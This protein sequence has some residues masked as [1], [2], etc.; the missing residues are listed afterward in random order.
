MKQDLLT[1]SKI[2]KTK[3]R[4]D[5]I[6]VI[7][8]LPKAHFSAE[9]VLA[10]LKKKKRRVSRA[11]VYRAIKLFSKRGVLRATDLGQGFQVYELAT[12]KSHHDHLY[13]I[14]CGNIIEFE[15][16]TI[17]RLQAKACKENRFYH[18]RHTLRIIGLCKECKKC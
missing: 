9:D 6:V 12:N 8:S 2:R 15:D 10:G 18:L 7:S 1:Q 14:K 3:P 4:Q 5:I 13:C 16:E 11:S 17:E